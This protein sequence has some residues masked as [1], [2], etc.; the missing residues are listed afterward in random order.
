MSSLISDKYYKQLI[1]AT[2][3]P[4]RPGK[5]AEFAHLVQ[6]IV[7]NHMLNGETIRLDGAVRMMM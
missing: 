2:P 1:S 7:E 3:F 5:A 6:A 4:K